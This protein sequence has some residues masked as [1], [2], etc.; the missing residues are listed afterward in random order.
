MSRKSRRSG[1]RESANAVQGAEHRPEARAA[2]ARVAAVRVRGAHALDNWL[3]G[4]ALAGIALSAYLTLSA[5]FGAQP[6]FCAAGSDCD[7]V[8][9]SR[10]SSLLG[11]PI[12]LWGMLTYALLARLI[13][14]LRTRPSAWRAALFFAVIG[15]GVSWYLAAISFFVIEALCTYCLTSFAIANALLVLLLVRRPAHMP[16]HAWGQALPAPLGA[17]VVIVAVLA[18]HFGGMFDPAAGPEKPQLK[19]LAVHLSETGA[20]FYGTYWC[21]VCQQQKALFEASADRLPYVE[22]TPGGRNGPVSV[23]CVLNDIKS[24]PTWI[25]G[26]GRHTGIVTASELARLSGYD[27]QADSAQKK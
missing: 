4:L 8:Q 12:A 27:W 22:C 7:L 24:Y 3:F 2:K 26:R 17:A 5:W 20:R 23:E 13:W 6:A 21:P 10:W 11:A 19:A 18:M 15:A 16:E 1:K 9:Q 14:R 25:I